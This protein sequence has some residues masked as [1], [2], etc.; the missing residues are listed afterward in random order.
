MPC[1]LDPY[2]DQT[3][4]VDPEALE[5]DVIVISQYPWT[6]RTEKYPLQTKCLHHYQ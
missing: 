2:S 5:G 3:W 1:R 4:T 6:R